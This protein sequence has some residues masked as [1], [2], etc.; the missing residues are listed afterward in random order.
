VSKASRVR[1]AKVRCTARRRE[2]DA[3]RCSSKEE[4]PS[5]VPPRKPYKSRRR[6]RGIALTRI[7]VRETPHKEPETPEED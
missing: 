5:E 6:D 3:V 7:F 1:R 2:Q 4:K